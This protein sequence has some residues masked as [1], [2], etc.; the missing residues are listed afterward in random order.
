M[1]DLV[2]VEYRSVVVLAVAVDV[3]SSAGQSEKFGRALRE[4]ARHPTHVFAIPH[5]NGQ[6]GRCT[7]DLAL[8]R[9]IANIDPLCHA[10]TPCRL[11]LLL[12]RIIVRG[13]NVRLQLGAWD[14]D[15]RVFHFRCAWLL[16]GDFYFFQC[17]CPRR[18]LGGSLP[19]F[20]GDTF[21]VGCRTVVMMIALAP[22]FILSPYSRH[23]PSRSA[24]LS[25][26]LCT[27]YY[28]PRNCLAR[29]LSLCPGP[30]PSRNSSCRVH[31]LVLS[32]IA[33]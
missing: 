3:S 11:L 16:Q 20:D 32:S 4:K 30:A 6:V 21:P 22:A 2:R 13:S 8:A 9:Q 24:N 7:S 26:S 25:P 19:F 14:V 29:S 15:S 31:H 5:K 18:P 17:F 33:W 23:T 12:L 10:P 27:C 1:L 28:E